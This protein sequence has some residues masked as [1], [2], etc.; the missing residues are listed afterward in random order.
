MEALCELFT[1]CLGLR[2][3][4]GNILHFEIPAFTHSKSTVYHGRFEFTILFFWFILI[5][6]GVYMPRVSCYTTRA[7]SRRC[8]I[9][10]FLKPGDN[11]MKKKI[12][13]FSTAFLISLPIVFT[14][15]F[16]GYLP[17]R[18]DAIVYTDNIVGEGTCSS[19]LTDSQKSFSFLYEGR[20]YFGSE[21]KTLRLPGLQYNVKNVSLYMYDIEEVDIISFDISLFD[22]TIAHMSK[23]GVTHPLTP[24]P[25]EAVFTGEEPLAHLVTENG[26]IS[27]SFS[28]NS[29]IP[30]WIWT[31]YFAFILLIALGVAFFLA[32]LLERMPALRLPLMSAAA[33]IIT[34]LA[35]CFV[36]DSLPYVNYTDFLLNFALLFSAVLLVNA[37]TLPWLGTAL[38][39]LFTYAW[40]L[41][42]CFVIHFRSRPI[43][44][45]DLKAIGTAKEVVGSYDLTPTW[46][47]AAGMAVLLLYLTAVFL[48]WKKSIPKEK[49]ELKKRL[50]MRGACATVAL[51]LAFLS[52]NNP[53][54]DSVNTFQWD[55]YVVEGFHREGIVLT[56]VKNA[57]SSHVRKPD[58][59]S[60]ELVDAYLA[61]Y[62]QKQTVTGPQPVRIIMVMNEAFSDLRTVGVDSSIDV[63][64]FIDSLDENTIEGSLFVSIIGGGTCNTEFEALTGNTLAFLSSGAYPYTENVT[65]PLFSLAEYFRNN[66]AYLT[67]AF[68]ANEAKNWNRNA[69]Y[70]NLGFETFHSV[71]DYPALTSE[72]YLR[73]LYITDATDYSFME[74]RDAA[75]EGKNRFLFNVTIQNHADYDHFMDLEEAAVLKPYED[76][77]DQCVR[78]YL[79]LIKVSDDSI[80]QLVET[81]R[82][83]D[84]PTMIVFFGD[85]QPT[86]T[87]SAAAK[88]YTNTSCHLDYYKSKFFIWTNYETETVHE[89]AVSANYLPWLV[90]E[91]GNFPLPPYVQ[92]LKELHEKYPVISSQGVIDADGYIYDN[93]AMLEDDP[94]IQKYRNIQYANMFDEIDPAWF[95]VNP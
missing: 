7:F 30:G 94:L 14:L 89:A 40:Y 82:D 45:A 10:R 72:N 5:K 29:V 86:F 4:A 54:F 61:D 93:V 43:M 59:Y 92:M 77:L 50:A 36:C 95:Q 64:P 52:V 34:M 2:N 42:D 88:V 49:P 32:F 8:F 70:P 66:G 48:A 33:V 85:H 19:Y 80:R 27:V 28:G 6:S 3:A 65:K 51:L 75:D 25:R 60:R 41:A 23:N 69:V 87:A 76:S 21:L 17:L 15:I 74:Q 22:R 44:L 20:A 35:G 62:Q 57:I 79:S 68:H 1:D 83:S 47:M 12:I 71:D 38:V 67:E 90:L 81:Y 73:G 24:T 58:G 46:Q 11:Q 16:F 78:V 13:S 84:E 18:F 9:R 91:R 39:S 37:L 63:M 55:A 26:Q 31:A 53:V 56:F